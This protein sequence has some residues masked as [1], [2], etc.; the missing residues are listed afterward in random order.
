MTNSAILFHDSEAGRNIIV[1]EVS[2]TLS[3]VSIFEPLL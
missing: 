3:G 1:S 2:E